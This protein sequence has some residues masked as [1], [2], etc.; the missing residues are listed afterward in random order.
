[1][2]LSL[3]EHVDIILAPQRITLARYGRG[4]KV[5][6]RDR[7]VVE[8]AAAN[9]AAPWHPPLEALREWLS[10]LKSGAMG[11]HVVLSSHFVRYLL[12]PW[13]ATV[14]GE[15]EELALASA[16][17]VQVYGEIAR[18]WAVRVSSGAPGTPLLAAAVDSAFLDAIAALLGKSSLRLRSLQPALMAACN[19]QFANVAANAWVA[20]AEPGQL[21][22]GL[23]RDG[24]W[25]S[26]R[27]RPIDG[28]RV[29][30]AEVIEQERLL[31]GVDAAGEKVYVHQWGDPA[32]DAQ[33]LN[34]ERW[35]GRDTAV[36]SRP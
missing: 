9:D 10:R 22:L 33:G 15:R 30:L 19:M 27:S 14:A 7:S 34:V 16:R 18:S 25:K 29:P 36:A 20:I 32:I 21:L 13:N 3:R 12:V 31:L 23:Q 17:F 28:G 2:S 11:A 26:L 6:A 35:S 8:C 4:A 5:A 24:Q 1:M